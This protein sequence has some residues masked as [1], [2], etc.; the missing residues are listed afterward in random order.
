MRKRFSPACLLMPMLC[1]GIAVLGDS[2]LKAT[3]MLLKDID[4]DVVLTAGKAHNLGSSLIDR[5]AA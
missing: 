4:N 5:R 1:F 3:G 2:A